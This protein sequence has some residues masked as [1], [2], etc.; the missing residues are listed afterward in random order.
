MLKQ[1]LQWLNAILDS[2]ERAYYERND[3]ELNTNEAH[4]HPVPPNTPMPPGYPPQSLNLP[5]V[6]PPAFPPMILK[7][8][9]AIAWWEGAK[10]ESNNPG[11]IKY[12][13]LAASWGATKG[14]KAADGGYFA[15]FATHKAGYDALCN[16]L[17]LACND[18]LKAY[19]NARTLTAFTKIYAGNPPAGYINGIRYAMEVPGETLISTFL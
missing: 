14:R 13:S 9:N 8:A 15:Q 5:P 7:W 16:F 3:M 2:W 12:A 17:V 19:H 4:D 18:E 1:F 6:A 10:P 11:N